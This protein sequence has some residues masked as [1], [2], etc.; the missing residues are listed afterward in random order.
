MPQR[1][2]FHFE[3]HKGWMNDPNG[4]IYY[5]DGTML[6]FQH[7]PHE[8]VWGPMHWGMLSV[9]TCCTGKSCPSRCFPISPMKM[10][11]DAFLAL[12]WSG[13][14][15]CTCSIRPYQA[16]GANAVRSGQPRQQSL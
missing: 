9:R 10:I 4:L 7:N 12:L 6:F 5:Q 11:R 15:S 8:P 2:T 13:M 3:P 14:A 16:T 1:F